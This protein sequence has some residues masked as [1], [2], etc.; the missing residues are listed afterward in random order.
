MT[1]APHKYLCPISLDIMRDPICVV[2]GD[3]VQRFDRRSL[4]LHEQTEHKD[5]N[6]VTNVTGFSLALRIPDHILKAE[7]EEHHKEEIKEEE[8]SDLSE[9]IHREPSL[10]E[11]IVI[12]GTGKNPQGNESGPVFDPTA[13]R[14]PVNGNLMFEALHNIFHPD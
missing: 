4:E 13:P 1:E 9:P 12:M 7:I 14:R 8:R 6:P 10:F 2:H 11:A 5:R 3:T